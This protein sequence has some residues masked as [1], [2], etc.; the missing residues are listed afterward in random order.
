MVTCTRGWARAELGRAAA[1][2][3]QRAVVP[4]TPRRDVA[5]DLV[6]ARGHVGGDVVEL[7]QHPPGPLDDDDALVGQAAPLAVD[8]GDAELALEAGDVAAD[9]GL[10]GV[11]GTWRLPRTSR[12][13]RSPRAWRAGGD[14]SRK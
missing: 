2:S 4:I 11:Q 8:Q 10:H 12:D 7:V 5:G 14:P 1:G 13:R 3:S 9:V 6:A